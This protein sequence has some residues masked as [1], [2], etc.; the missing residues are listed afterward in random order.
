MKTGI[1]EILLIGLAIFWLM[2]AYRKNSILRKMENHVDS[3]IKKKKK[4][5]KTNKT[6]ISQ[7]EDVDALFF[8]KKRKI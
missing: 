5:S 6:P 8:E 4:S 2:N 7:Y 1:W 3:E